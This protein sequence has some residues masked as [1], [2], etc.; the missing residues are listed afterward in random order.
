LGVTIA[1]A[2]GLRSIA[3]ECVSLSRDQFGARLDWSLE[4][5][6]EVDRICEELLSEDPPSDKRRDLW[7]KLLG[8]YTGEVMVRSYGGRWVSHERARGAYAIEISEIIGFPFSTVSRV[9]DG[10]PFKSVASFGRVFP[11]IRDQ[12]G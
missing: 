6:A 8:A 4:S 12:A 10:E 3:E 7:W 2:D 5:L 11:A 1:D 9:L